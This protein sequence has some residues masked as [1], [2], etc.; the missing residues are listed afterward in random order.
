M[1]G[2]TLVSQA[3]IFPSSSCAT[4]EIRLRTLTRKRK[5]GL[6]RR[7]NHARCA[8]TPV[9]CPWKISF[10]LL[11]RKLRGSSL[12]HKAWLLTLQMI[13]LQIVAVAALRDIYSTRHMFWKRLT[14]RSQLWGPPL[15][16]LRSLTQITPS[17]LAT[18]ETVASYTTVRESARPSS[19]SGEKPSRPWVAPGCVCGPKF[20][21]TA[22]TYLS[23]FACC[24]RSHRLRD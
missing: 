14:L 17:R 8:K 24:Q 1:A 6:K 11:V 22:S 19:R 23:R 15:Q 3:R 4:V 5:R 10:K 7:L 13:K 20:R 18:W 16:F 21:R 9:S 12:H 2:K